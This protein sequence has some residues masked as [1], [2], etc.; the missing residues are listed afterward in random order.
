M[1][2]LRDVARP[3]KNRRLIGAAEAVA[4]DRPRRIGRRQREVFE[5][6]DDAEIELDRGRRAGAADQK[7]KDGKS[8]RPHPIPHARKAPDPPPDRGFVGLTGVLF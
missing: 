4:H 1:P 2:D 8:P 3:Q 7:R 5:R 6:L